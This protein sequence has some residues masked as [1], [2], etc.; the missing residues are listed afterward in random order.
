MQADPPFFVAGYLFPYWE[1]L[2]W[3][4]CHSPF[5]YSQIVHWPGPVTVLKRFM[6]DDVIHPHLHL[7]L[8]LSV[9]IY[10]YFIHIHIYMIIYILCIYQHIFI[11]SES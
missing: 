8:Y 11:V 3:S 6:T 7:H 2:R 1:D 5:L 4:E 10:K 9:Y